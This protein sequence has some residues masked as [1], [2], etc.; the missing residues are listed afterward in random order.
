MRGQHTYQIV[1]LPALGVL[2]SVPPMAS[3][4]L[5]EHLADS[6]G[7]RA[8]VEALLLLD[9]LLQREAY[10]AGEIEQVT[11]AVLSSE[12]TRN[13]VALPAYLA[14]PPGAP[15]RAVKVDGLWEDYFRYA[16]DTATQ[17]RSA[18]LAGWIGHEVALRNALVV[19][20]ARQLALEASDYLVAT[21]LADSDQDLTPVM[22]EWAA[23][24]TP[25]AGLRVLV[26]ARWAWISHHEAWFTF[27]DDEMVAYA[28]KLALLQQWRRSAQGAEAG[29]S[30]DESNSLS[31]SV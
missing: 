9:D 4:Q 27:N 6:D 23:A 22:S 26:K 24:P 12:Q 8:L 19:M 11:P 21:E 5:M 17:R 15:P 16:A 28:G 30:P 25:L 18:F 10:L 2:G 20:R 29:A 1:A 13:E 31:Q 3:A 7:P 14:P